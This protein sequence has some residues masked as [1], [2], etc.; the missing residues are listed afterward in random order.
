MSAAYL[1]IADL[2]REAQPPENGIL[3]RTI[4][5][6]DRIKAVLFGFAAGQELSEHT[7]STP[8]TLQFLSGEATLL[9][10]EDEKPAGPGTFVQMGA[11]LK[12]AIHAKTP[13]VMLLLLHKDK[14]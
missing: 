11:G 5:Q 2:C 1:H 9:L 13:T 6:D 8:A 10:G 7:A 12:H 3:S 14:A 4:Y